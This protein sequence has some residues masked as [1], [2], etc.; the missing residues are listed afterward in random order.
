MFALYHEFLFRPLLNALIAIYNNLPVADMGLAIIVL[1]LAVRFLLYPLSKKAI[2]SQLELKKL[3]PQIAEIQKKHSNKQEQAKA[4]MALY[5]EHK[6]NPFSGCLPILIQ[7]PILIALYQVFLKG[8]DPK[9]FNGLYSFVSHPSSINALFL[10]LTNLSES[11]FALALLAGAS[12]FFQTK[13]IIPAK[14]LAGGERDFSSMMNQQ[15]L[16]V[17]PVLTVFIAMSLPAA[18]ALF[19]FVTNVFSIVQQYTFAKHMKESTL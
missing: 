12:Q 9:N 19:W 5:Q 11:S 4:M 8:F 18:L 7:L 2:R 3:Q 15:M 13:M 16:Y 1:T 14:P 17:M 10:G 6:I